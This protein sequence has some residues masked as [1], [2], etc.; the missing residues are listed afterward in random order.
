MAESLLQT[1]YATAMPYILTAS[2]GGWTDEYDRQR[3]LSYDLYDD[4]Y[5]N[6]PSQYK[7]M[8]R[9]TNEKP[10][11]VPTASKL[12][13]SLAR[14]VG[15]GWGYT[16]TASEADEVNGVEASTPE[17]LTTAMSAFG[18]LFARERLLSKFRS[19]VP[20]W[21]RRGDWLWYVSA[22]PLK[23]EGA[24]ISVRPVDPRRYFPVNGDP[25]DLSHIT[26]QQLIEETILPDGKTM[27]LLVQTWLKSSDP[28][29]PNYGSP[30]PEEGFPITHQV[31]A[32]D[33]ADY[34]DPLKRKALA[35]PNNLPQ[36]AIAGITQLPIYHIKNNEATDDP[37]GRSD[38]AGL[39]S[40]VSGI[41]QAISDEDLS[42]ALMGL[43]M[44]WTNSG[45][46]VDEQT[47]QPTGWKLGPNRVIEVDEDSTFNKVVG[48]DSVQPFQDH[49]DF[50]GGEAASNMGLSDVSIGTADNINAESGIALSIKFSPTLDTV[51]G[52]NDTINSTLSQ[53]FHDLKQWFD[54]F[55]GLDC[56]TV[57]VASVTEDG[58]LLP[59]DREARWK[60]LMEGV[61]AGVFT[62][63]FAVKIL[64][65]EFGY[66]FDADYLSQLE[67]AD[68]KAAATLDP[69][70][71]RANAEAAATDDEDASAAEDAA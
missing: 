47:Q 41:N 22:D 19:G 48:I 52:K 25:L 29:H 55:E 53:M 14:Y 4:L 32:Y 71:A 35:H 28:N 60:E 40:I 65:Q 12:V 31:Q 8:L 33:L 30:E 24:R 49:V 26:G 58:D 7:L 34:A 15:K 44:Y 9:G 16:C 62:K 39:E 17:Q 51:R 23:R 66:V 21:L 70:A 38:L 61:T 42:L 11:Y 67:A 68:E 36:A 69:F 27:G 1:P 2:A 46:P 57:E 56:G 10:I 64:E 43:G 20:E 59:F 3:M 13:K 45:A 63:P 37:F 18:N 5:N 6:D 50:I 54:V